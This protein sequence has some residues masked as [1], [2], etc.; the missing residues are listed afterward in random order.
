LVV[1]KC[2]SNA[3]GREFRSIDRI[4]HGTVGSGSATIAL[5]SPAFVRLNVRLL[6]L[7]LLHSLL[8]LGS[9]GLILG[10]VVQRLDPRFVYLQQRRTEHIAPPPPQTLLQNI[11]CYTVIPQRQF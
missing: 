6:E 3:R 8:Q 7:Q 5:Q 11:R 4:W 1:T 9:Q 2:A 10:G